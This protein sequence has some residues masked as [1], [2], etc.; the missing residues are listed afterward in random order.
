MTRSLSRSAQ[1]FG[2]DGAGFGNDLAADGIDNGRENHVS[3]A[4]NT[5]ERKLKEAQS[6]VF[7]RVRCREV[8]RYTIRVVGFETVEAE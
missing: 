4:G 8:R 5:L 1:V 2:G 3:P 7:S 6:F